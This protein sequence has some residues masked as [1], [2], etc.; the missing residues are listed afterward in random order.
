MCEIAVAKKKKKR[1]L[2]CLYLHGFHTSGYHRLKLCQHFKILFC[3][4]SANLICFPLPLIELQDFPSI[5]PLP[6]SLISFIPFHR[7]SMFSI[8]SPLLSLH[9]HVL[10]VK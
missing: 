3:I 10:A 1:F 6:S 4:L 7:V 5:T 8:I 9:A 2:P